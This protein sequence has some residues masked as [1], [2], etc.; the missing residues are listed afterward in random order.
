[1]KYNLKGEK[2]R[3]YMYIDF[4]SASDLLVVFQVFND[5]CNLRVYC[6]SYK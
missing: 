1:M 2:K 3:Y 6:T 5:F 4:D